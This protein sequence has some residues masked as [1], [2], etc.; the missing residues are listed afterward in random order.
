MTATTAAPAA[1]AT[2]RP[3]D[4][5]VVPTIVITAL[6]VAVVLGF[7]R[8]FA[9]SSF[10]FPLLAAAITGHAIAWWGRRQ[11]WPTAASA[12]AT[13][14]GVAV[15][16]AWTILPETTFF[17]IPTRETLTVAG[18]ELSLARTAFRSAVAPAPVL[19]GFV[20]ASAVAVATIAVMADWAAFRI[21]A[22]FE[23]CVPAFTL[24]LFTAALGTDRHRGLAL[25]LFVGAVLAFLLSSQLSRQTRT[26]TWF[27]GRPGLGPMWLV[28]AGAVLGL[29]AV[30]AGLFVGPSLPGADDE[31][32]LRYKNSNRPGPANRSTVSPLV[33][34]R[35]RL[36]E[37]AGIE[38]FTV[39]SNQRAYWR[40]T[41]LDTFDG[42]IWSSNDKYRSAGGPL[43][44]DVQVAPDA[45][46]AVQEFSIAS[47]GSI[48]LPAA[49]RPERVSGVDDVAYNSDTGSL[50]TDQDVADGLTY[51][52]QSKIPTL[53]PEQLSTAP[54]VAP[55]EILLGYGTQPPVSPRVRAEANRIVAGATTPYARAKALQDYF[56]RGFRYDLNAR[57]GHG[58][59]ALERFL[60]RTRAGY[61]EQFAG[62]YAVLARLVGLPSR[63]AVGFTPGE[64]QADGLFHVRD[65]HAHAWP[66]VYLHGFGWVAFE[67]TPG[68]G[69]PGAERYTG[70]PEQQDQSGGSTTATTAAPTPTTAPAENDMAPATTAPQD[71]PDLST[72]ESPESDDDKG[73][74]RVL[75]GAGLV[76]LLLLLWLGGVPLLVA[77][78]RNR[79]R[80]AAETSADRVVVAWNE[81]TEA[82]RQTGL[83]RRPA[84][85][86]AEYAA[87]A[88]R[89]A[90]MP[91][92][93]AAALRQ[94]ATDAA[95]ATFAGGALPDEVGERSQAGA[96]EIVNTLRDR[97]GMQ[98]RVW[99]AVDPRQLR[100][101]PQAVP[102]SPTTTDRNRRQPAA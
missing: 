33:D 41:S 52:V 10:L 94:L 12:I 1:T 99:R 42:S 47:L 54:A 98:E 101:P 49:F 18:R 14:M 48:W 97:A 7:V 53:G 36:V 68:R 82:L 62:A 50:I 64:L 100:R 88:G 80:A 45:T 91:E 5:T 72:G 81:V 76:L 57:P 16:A 102:S 24:F 22:P 23:A 29:V 44:T 87:R 43:R 69:A 37:R 27:G 26:G 55:N 38:V 32:L 96:A 78:R 89:R 31:A 58:S 67:P 60:F 90:D 25:V 3:R 59:E 84:E 51:Q 85:T 19:D 28:Q 30:L 2:A 65:E 35:G 13:L 46:E 34:I 74:S 21:Q 9:D 73:P 15:V 63:V 39:K 40:L 6:T 77:M 75:I 17:G 83:P 93:A 66:E 61:C 92:P 95:A 70:L 8:L 79:L 20:L 11:E 56:H 86:P 4:T 71:V